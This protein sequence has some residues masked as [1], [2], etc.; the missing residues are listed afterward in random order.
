MPR[1]SSAAVATPVSLPRK[2]QHLEHLRTVGR[3]PDLRRAYRP[4]LRRN[5]RDAFAGEH[6]GTL[7]PRSQLCSL[8]LTAVMGAEGNA[9][10]TLVDEDH[11]GILLPVVF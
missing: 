9:L 4:V 6:A 10:G 11:R 7:R 2:R 1:G 3:L 5:A 8:P